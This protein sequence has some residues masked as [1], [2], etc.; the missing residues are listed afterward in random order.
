M[1]VKFNK[2]SSLIVKRALARF[3]TGIDVQLHFNKLFF[4]LAA[5][6]S[7][8]PWVSAPLALI[9]GCLFA[10]FIGNPFPRQSAKVS[11]WLLK[12]AIIGLGFSMNLENA[13][14]AGRDGFWLTLVTIGLMLGLGALLGKMLGMPRR[15][16]W[17]LAS[18]TAICGGSAIAAVGPAVQAN[19]KEMSV[20]LGVVFLLNALALLLFPVLGHLLNMDATHFGLWCAVAIHDTSSVVGAAATYGVDAL[21]VATTVK[22][23]RALW[24]IPLTLVS[25]LL[26]KSDNRKLRLPL[27]ILGFVLV[28]LLNSYFPVPQWFGDGVVVISRAS[29]SLCLFL[30]GAALNFESVRAV[31]WK[32]LGL[33]LILWIVCILVSLPAILF[34]F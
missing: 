25:A 18:G 15:L 27:F 11:S 4:I 33:G 3:F 16:S 20:S 13:L 17:L 14:Q 22:L 19:A 12:A 2:N 31:G 7:L 9:G 6:G 34:L 29:L 26:F 1:K 32:P 8:T 23:A 5:V 28:I 24:I 10:Q 30:I 21:Q